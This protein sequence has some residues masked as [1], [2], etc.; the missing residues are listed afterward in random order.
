MADE[1][2][3]TA[4][5]SPRR[6]DMAREMGFLPTAATFVQAAGLI[7]AIALVYMRG[8]ALAESLHASIEETWRQLPEIARGNV[9]ARFLR[10]MVMGIAVPVAE[11]LLTVSLGVMAIMLLV[12][13]A[14][15]GGAWTPSLALPNFGRLWKSSLFSDEDS[16]SRL[17][18]ISHR[19]LLGTLRPLAIIAG[20]VLVIAVLKSRWSPVPPSDDHEHST[21]RSVLQHGRVSL[22]MG[23]TL[24]AVPIALLGA[25]EYVLNRLRWM[26]QL[27]PTSDQARRELRETEG[28]VE[29][30]SKRKKLVRRIR[31]TSTID[32]MTKQT[33]AVIVGT[34]FSGL[35]VQLMRTSG[36][37]LAVGQVLRGTISATFA[38]KAASMGIPWLRDG[39]LAARLAGMAGKPGDPP[40][41]MPA[42]LQ[43]D[44]ARRLARPAANGTER[45]T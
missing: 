25:V 4:A 5:P 33:A 9:T 44:I 35:S 1:E 39:K 36:G 22:G 38:E 14:T 21:L 40:T 26:D 37:R 31:E 16:S 23:L 29:W 24:L 43:A 28:D 17:P 32:A 7:G 2:D 42:V 45:T 11:P 8:P 20:C 30:K 10:A 6:I 12:H 19:L 3:R 41:E 13:Q 34:G 15:T 27:R 18:P